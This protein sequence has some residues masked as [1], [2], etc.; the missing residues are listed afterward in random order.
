MLTLRTRNLEGETVEVQVV[1]TGWGMAKEV[2][3]KALDPFYTTKGPDK[4]T[5][6]GLAIVHTTVQ[7]HHGQLELHSEPGQ[8]TQVYL[9]FPACAAETLPVPM[10]ATIPGD[11]PGGKLQVLVIDDDELMQETLQLILEVL[12]HTPASALCGEEAL[13]MVEAGYEPDVVILD[14]NMP[15]LGGTGTLPRLRL[16]RPALPVLIATGRPDQVAFDLAEAHPGVTLIAKP[17]GMRAL[18]Q[19]LDPFLGSGPT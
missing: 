8:G 11:R 17:F 3:L 6:L 2:L 7:A 12:G 16:L 14:M 13:R 19:Y 9:R 18:Q 1:D 5:G 4:G 15:G 10:A